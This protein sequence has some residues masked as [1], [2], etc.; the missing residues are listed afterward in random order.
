ML[1]KSVI[2][3]VD[4]TITNK[5]VIMAGDGAATLKDEVRAV[6]ENMSEADRDALLE[7]INS[8]LKDIE[9]C[10][11]PGSM[12]AEDK[13]DLIRRR[14]KELRVLVERI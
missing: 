13:L 5:G 10:F 3:I 7:K 11:L 14:C 6:F 8:G 4:K 12:S 2:L 9:D 1:I